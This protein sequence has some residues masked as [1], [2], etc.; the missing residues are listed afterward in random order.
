MYLRVKVLILDRNGVV[1]VAAVFFCRVVDGQTAV[2]V[3]KTR[4]R[5]SGEVAAS[6]GVLYGI[7]GRKCAGCY[8]YNADIIDI[9]YGDILTEHVHGGR[10]NFAIEVKEC[11]GT[12]RIVISYADSILARCADCRAV[13][14]GVSRAE[15]C[16]RYA[17]TALCVF[18]AAVGVIVTLCNEEVLYAAE[19]VYGHCHAV[20]VNA[21]RHYGIVKTRNDKLTAVVSLIPDRPDAAVGEFVIVVTRGIRAGGNY[22]RIDIDT[23]GSVFDLSRCGEIAACNADRIDV[24]RICKCDR[25]VV[26]GNVNIPRRNFACRGDNFLF[27]FIT[28]Y[29]DAMFKT[30]CG[31]GSGS[32]FYPLT[33]TVTQCRSRVRYVCIFTT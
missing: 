23:S 9:A 5:I 31:R 15:F 16:A 8:A 17:E 29:T 33:E 20:G 13:F 32:D 6:F 10:F 2:G 24:C 11:V 12:G 14:V 18:N 22:G 25:V 21:L 3:C 28:S 1:V 4:N 30:V 19:V 27:K 7:G 26:Y